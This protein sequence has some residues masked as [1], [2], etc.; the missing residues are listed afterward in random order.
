MAVDKLEFKKYLTTYGITFDEYKAMNEKE[1]LKLM[2]KYLAQQRQETY[3]GLADLF[4]GIGCL[5]IL[6][7]IVAIW[8]GIMFNIF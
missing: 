4:K 7:P 5:A 3:K 6:I 1:K 2:E 8:L